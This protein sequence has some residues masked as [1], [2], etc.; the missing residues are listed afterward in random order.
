MQLPASDVD[1]TELVLSG[2]SSVELL[3]FFPRFNTVLFLTSAFHSNNIRSPPRSA[4]IKRSL[5]KSL[6]KVRRSKA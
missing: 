3:S 1:P 6:N 5:D 4:E 2:S